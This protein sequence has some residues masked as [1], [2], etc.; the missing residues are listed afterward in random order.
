MHWIIHSTISQQ[1]VCSVLL[2]ET[3]YKHKYTHSHDS[4]QRTMSVLIVCNIYLISHTVVFITHWPVW[5]SKRQLQ[6]ISLYSFPISDI[7][8]VLLRS[9]MRVVLEQNSACKLTECWNSVY[10]SINSIK[11]II[12]KV[13]TESDAPFKIAEAGSKCGCDRYSSAPVWLWDAAGGG[14]GRRLL[15][16]GLSAQ[17]VGHRSVRTPHVQLAEDARL[18]HL[19]LPRDGDVSRRKLVEEHL[20]VV[21]QADPLHRG[22]RAHV[23]QILGVDGLGIRDKRRRQNPCRASM[24]R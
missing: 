13:N 7:R 17:V 6:S 4:D 2:H 21:L 19:L 3:D 1:T 12:T 9:L 5:M 14:F 15:Q 20:V 23:V 16:D 24:W 8:S 22:E 10:G 11:S 18:D